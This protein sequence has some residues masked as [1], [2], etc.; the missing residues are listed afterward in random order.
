MKSFKV[1]NNDVAVIVDDN[2]NTRMIGYTMGNR[3]DVTFV[4]GAKSEIY[5]DYGRVENLSEVAN[6]MN[7]EGI[8]KM[9]SKLADLYYNRK[10]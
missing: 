5:I 3:V 1:L 4:G 9:Y 6:H 7:F 8:A 10:Y 2:N